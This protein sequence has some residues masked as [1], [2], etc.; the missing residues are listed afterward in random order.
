MGALGDWLTTQEAAELAEYHL[1]HIRRLIRVK[2]IEAKKWGRDWMVSR[3]SLL[4]YLDQTKAQ[5]ERRGPKKID[6]NK[7][8]KDML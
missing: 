5:G 8:A 7:K 3:E 4:A 2:E 6:S 1:N